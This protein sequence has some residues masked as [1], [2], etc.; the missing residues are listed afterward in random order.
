MEREITVHQPQPRASVPLIRVDCRHRRK[1][2][3]SGDWA[4]GK[5]AIAAPVYNP[6]GTAK[7][8][9]GTSILVE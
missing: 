4:S 9:T 6:K 7:H 5:C 1:F 3:D 8:H 2:F